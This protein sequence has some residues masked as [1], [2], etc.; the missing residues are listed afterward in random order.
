MKEE[1]ELLLNGQTSNIIVAMSRNDLLEFASALISNGG[2][3]AWLTAREVSEVFGI[4]YNNIKSAQWRKDSK[5][6]S[7]Q[8]GGAYCRPMFHAE[9]VSA[10]LR[11]Q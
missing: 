2:K 5:F 1:L 11:R 9:E 10:W 4:P 7:H 8:P 3:K 6:P